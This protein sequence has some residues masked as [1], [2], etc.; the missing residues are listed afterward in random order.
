MTKLEQ[1]DARIKEV[2]STLVYLLHERL[3][4]INSDGISKGLCSCCKHKVDAE[5][6]EYG[7]CGFCG[8]DV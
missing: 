1:I 5:T 4:L 8:G 2:E 7:T 3:A 6:K